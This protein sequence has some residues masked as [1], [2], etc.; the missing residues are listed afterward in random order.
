LVYGGSIDF[1]KNL[2]IPFNKNSVT[3]NYEAPLFIDQKDI[4]YSTQLSGLDEKWSDW[5]AQTTREYVNLP[6]G[7]YTFKIKAQNSYRISPMK[8]QFLFP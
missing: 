2:S 3:L 6:A 4:K 5:T 8:P 7:N 1:P